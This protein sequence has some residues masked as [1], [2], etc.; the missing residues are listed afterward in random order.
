MDLRVEIYSVPHFSSATHEASEPDRRP[1]FTDLPSLEVLHKNLLKFLDGIIVIL[2]KLVQPAYS[3]SNMDRRRGIRNL[4]ALEDSSDAVIRLQL[5]R[6]PRDHQRPGIERLDVFRRAEPLLAELD[7]LHPIGVHEVKHDR[8]DEVGHGD[9]REERGVLDVADREH[10]EGVTVFAV[11][12][13]EVV[14][15]IGG[16]EGCAGEECD[17]GEHKPEHAEEA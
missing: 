9:V 10:G 5:L 12:V 6:N 4:D 7:D 16:D 8:S 13:P 2:N 1:L 3:P 11:D 15:D 14:H 17:G